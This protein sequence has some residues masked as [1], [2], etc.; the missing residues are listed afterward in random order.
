[1]RTKQT[2]LLGKIKTESVLVVMAYQS[3]VNGS[4]HSLPQLSRRAT[5][6][7]ALQA[8]SSF[9]RTKLRGT[10]PQYGYRLGKHG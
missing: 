10:S 1:M 6:L 3:T 2:M 8:A 4:E 9:D 7:G 5:E